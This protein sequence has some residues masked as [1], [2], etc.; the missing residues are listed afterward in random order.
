MRIFNWKTLIDSKNGK[1]EFMESN[2]TGVSIHQCS[3]PFSEFDTTN[4]HS[5]CWGVDEQNRI[6]NRVCADNWL[7]A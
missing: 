4:I 5:Y 7:I 2:E 6:V 1:M 3:R